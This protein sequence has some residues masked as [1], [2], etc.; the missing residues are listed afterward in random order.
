MK[1]C[2]M[3]TIPIMKQSEFT[4]THSLVRY[5]MSLVFMVY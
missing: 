1:N 3:L 5:F 4:L 2:L